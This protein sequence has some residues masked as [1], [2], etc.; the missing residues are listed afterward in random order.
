MDQNSI[1]LMSNVLFLEQMSKKAKEK[2]NS[3][4]DYEKYEYNRI[5]DLNEKRRLYNDTL[6]K[7]I[8][9]NCESKLKRKGKNKNKDYRR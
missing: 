2:Y 7:G 4:S 5:K 9:P 1:E 3:L 8:C 6:S